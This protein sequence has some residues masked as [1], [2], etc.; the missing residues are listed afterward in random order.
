MKQTAIE[1]NEAVEIL[2]LLGDKT[3]LSTLKL[4]EKESLCVCE[5]VA[6]FE[7]SQ[8]AISQHLRKLKDLGLVEEERKGQWIF[9]SVNKN[10][11][12]YPFVQQIL[13]KLS[14]QDEKLKELEEKGARISCC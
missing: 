5:L 9:Y 12:F 2:K 3:R 7:M 14:S 4:L 1:I 8:P 10:N 13:E 11:E 6:I